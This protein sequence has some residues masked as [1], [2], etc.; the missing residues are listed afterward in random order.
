MKIYPINTTGNVPDGGGFTAT[1]TIQ[2]E[3]E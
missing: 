3:I 2:A 1:A